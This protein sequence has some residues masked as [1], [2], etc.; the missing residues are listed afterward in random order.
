MGRGLLFVW[1]LQRGVLVLLMCPLAHFVY[2]HHKQLGVVAAD[3]ISAA[4][5]VYGHAFVA[6]CDICAVDFAASQ[7]D[8]PTYVAHKAEGAKQW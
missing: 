7:V 6:V 3:N 4:G 1:A 5:G 8:V 2:G